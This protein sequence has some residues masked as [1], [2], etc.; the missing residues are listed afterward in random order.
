MTK[1]VYS[2]LLSGLVYLVGAFTAAS[3]DINTWSLEA[4]G[5]AAIFML[6]G[7]SVSFLFG[8]TAERVTNDYRSRA[9]GSE[10][11]GG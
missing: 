9:L 1:F 7:A 10:D 5:V 11:R 8:M 4:R 2:V 3:F 6:C